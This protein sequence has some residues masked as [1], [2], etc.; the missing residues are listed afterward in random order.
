MHMY[1]YSVKWHTMFPFINNG[2]E[3]Q[4]SALIRVLRLDSLGKLCFGLLASPIANLIKQQ[5]CTQCHTQL[6]QNLMNFINTATPF[7][8]VL[9]KNYTCRAPH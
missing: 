4:Y 2:G 3:I 1:I 5:I 9:A 6:L 8:Q 7:L